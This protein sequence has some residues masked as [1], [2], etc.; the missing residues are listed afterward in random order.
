MKPK[1]IGIIYDKIVRPDTI[2]V[3]CQKAL[4]QL[5]HN[6]TYF[7]IRSTVG[8]P[9]KDQFDLFLQIDDDFP[10]YLPAWMKPLAYF[11]VD[12]HRI[13]GP[14]ATHSFFRLDNMP[15][16]RMAKAAQADWIFT[17][18]VNKV[19]GFQYLEKNAF[20]LY[21]GVDTDIWKP[22][23][24]EKKYDWCFIGEIYE[25]RIP[26]IEAMKAAFPNYFVGKATPEECAKIYSQSRIVLNVTFTDI[27][28]R[29]FEAMACKSC[30][31]TSYQPGIGSFI[32]ISSTFQDIPGMIALARFMLSNN[33]YRS[34]EE[35]TNFENS[36]KHT[37]ISRMSDLME[38]V[39]PD[40]D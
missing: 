14:G 28:M 23:Y 33:L 13:A 8:E 17:P 5:G 32:S 20:Q 26:Y 10:Y 38:K 27:N 29:V 4:E 1:R 7:D 2:G 31:L 30:L 6:V 39:F 40:A 34:N 16:W 3:H 18:V 25:E 21:A 36:K 12:G 37:Y 11:M 24:L 19:L 9:P 35:T 22:H 15:F